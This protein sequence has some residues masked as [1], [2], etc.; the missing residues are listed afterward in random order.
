MECAGRLPDNVPHSFLH[1]ACKELS[2]KM[3]YH[4]DISKPPAFV[5]TDGDPWQCNDIL[6]MK[7]SIKGCFIRG[8]Q[9]TDNGIVIKPGIYING[10][11]TNQKCLIKHEWGHYLMDL[12]GKISTVSHSKE[13]SSHHSLMQGIGYSAYICHRERNARK[14][15]H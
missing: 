7:I 5:F 15:T 3:G 9:E 12:N 13:Y 11:S 1:E 6:Q 10:N 4:T 2:S 14:N 8:Y